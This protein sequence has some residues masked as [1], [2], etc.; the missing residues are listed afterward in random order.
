VTATPSAFTTAVVLGRGNDVKIHQRSTNGTTWSAWSALP[1]DPTPL[2][3][4][5]D[6]DCGTDGSG[7][8]HIVGTG[9]NPI[10]ALMHAS[11][12]GSAFNAFFRELPSQTF[13]VPGAAIAFSPFNTDYLLGALSATGLTVDNVSG[14]TDTA[15]TPITTI[16]N[17]LN[18]AIDLSVIGSL[19]LVV[20]FDSSS[21]LATYGRYVTGSSTSWGPAELIQPP[22]GTS[23]S[24]SPTV[25]GDDGLMA[26]NVVH[27]VAVASGQVWDTWTPD[28]SSTQFSAWER[29]GTQGASAPDCTM[30][31]DETVH[32]V[33]LSSAGHILDIYGSPDTWTTT[34]LGTF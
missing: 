29:I 34:D 31:G 6:L 16:V 7:A 9:S 33:T 18:S 12:S 3:V 11:G 30:M 19:Q 24:F 8:L 14:G 21:Q 25:C 5:S 15:I 20:A 13:S 28:W 4:R 22:N 23:F 1:L 26:D 27:V 10:G 32:V 17:P 2:D